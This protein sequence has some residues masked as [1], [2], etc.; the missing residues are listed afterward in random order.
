MDDKKLS[1]I[2]AEHAKAEP[3]TREGVDAVLALEQQLKDEPEF[4]K[5]R[6]IVSGRGG[7]GWLPQFAAQKMLSLVRGGRGADAAV[8][9]LRKAPSITRGSGGAVKLLYGVQCARSIAVTEDIV[10]LPFSEVPQSTIRE[11]IVTEHER[12]NEFSLV[13]GFT[14]APSAALYRAGTVEP[15]FVDASRD[16]HSSAPSTWFNDMDDAARLLA[17]IPKAIPIEAAHWFHY[18][19]PDVAMLGQFGLSRQGP[20]LRPIMTGA[21]VDVAVADVAGIFAAYK[22]LKESDKGRVNLALDRIMR[23]R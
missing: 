1:A 5:P 4:L 7:H 14:A 12:A 13:H 21:P 2:V 15:I 20:E 8:A 17:L 22:K 9:W 16:L 10:L 18:D 19:D 6:M 3:N 23:S 11:W